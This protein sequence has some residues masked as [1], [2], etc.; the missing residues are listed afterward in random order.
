[1][2]VT[3][4]MYV[5]LFCPYCDRAKA[6]LAQKGIIPVVIDISTDDQKRQD[7]IERSQGR[8]TVPQIF[9][10]DRHIGGCDE[11]Y[12]LNKKGQLDELLQSSPAE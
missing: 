9:I 11:L 10:D 6:L 2:S 4:V 7:M 5:T 8:K 1:M 12:D 3:V